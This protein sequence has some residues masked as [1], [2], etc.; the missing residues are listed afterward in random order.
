MPN[1]SKRNGV[2]GFN[3][4]VPVRYISLCSG[5]GGLDLGLRMAMPGAR[6]VCYVEIEAY[7]CEVLA[8]RMEEG[9]LDPAPI[10]T[11]LKTFDGLQWSGK[12]DCIIGGYPCQPFSVAGKRRGE[13]DPRHLWPF[14]SNIV[15]VVRPS[16]C[17]F[18]NVPG[19]VSKG[20]RQV[21]CDLESMGYRVEAGLFSAEE[22]GAP[23]KRERLFIMAHSD[24]NELR[25]EPR[26][27]DGKDRDSKAEP[28]DHGERPDDGTS[29]VHANDERLEG[30]RLLSGERKGQRFAWP[31]GP[32]DAAGWASWNGPQPAILRGAN[33]TANRVDRLRACGNG[34]VPHQAAYA[35]ST[36]F[37][38]VMQGIEAERGM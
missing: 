24:G 9:R 20:L 17:F 8:S 31:P 15:S 34:V 30:R 14:I 4:A 38:R 1:A 32:S 3:V 28:R 7:A 10:W 2:R 36:M 6:A 29:L 22:I 35:F 18:E 26:W 16:M 37:N 33:G 11:D 23:H 21:R 5:I 19:H 25:D 13:E 12:V 27:S